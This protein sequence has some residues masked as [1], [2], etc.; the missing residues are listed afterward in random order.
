MKKTEKLLIDITFDILYKKGYCATSLTD[1]LDIA[2]LTKGAMYYHFESKNALVL[3][4]MQHYLEMILQA[5]W[6]APFEMGENP[7]ETI[8]KQINLYLAMFESEE[9][10]LN[11]KHGCPLSNFILDMSNKDDEFFNYLQSVYQ[12]WQNSIAKA[13][14]K[15]KSLEQTSTE[16]DAQAEALF[17]ISSVEGCIG[18]AKAYNNI[19][20]LR[21]SFAVLANYVHKL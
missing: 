9:A 6:I 3:A 8:V 18:S 16:F 5:H 10:F 1:I 11:I 15:A 2:K 21:K 17:I 14:E 4:T 12:R 20:I 13:L 7:K 19:E